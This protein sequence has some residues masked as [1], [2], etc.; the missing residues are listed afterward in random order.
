MYGNKGKVC[1]G[2]MIASNVFWQ[3][4]IL[5]ISLLVF[6]QRVRAINIFW[7][8]SNACQLF[9]QE[10]VGVVSKAEIASNVFWVEN[11]ACIMSLYIVW[12]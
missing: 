5:A 11:N 1:V 3:K 4:I 12:Q 7:V 10:Y 9:L 8:Q 6:M 2:G